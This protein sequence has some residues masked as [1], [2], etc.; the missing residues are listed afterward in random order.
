MFQCNQCHTEFG[1]IRGIS[2]DSCPRCRQQG[3]AAEAQRSRPLN[4]AT[5]WLSHQPALP[6]W[7]PLPLVGAIAQ[8]DRAARA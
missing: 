1:G 4:A 5:A 7:S 2:A 6:D 3:S 8:L